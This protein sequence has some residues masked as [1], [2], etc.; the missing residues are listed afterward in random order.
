M[1]RK[2]NAEVEEQLEEVTIRKRL[3]FEDTD[4]DTDNEVTFCN[5]AHK[6]RK[7]LKDMEEM[8]VW[9]RE[10]IKAGLVGLATSDQVTKIADEVKGHARQ[11]QENKEESRKNA[12]NIAVIQK[13]IENIE[14]GI[15]AAP[16]ANLSL[17]HI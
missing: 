2:A 15:V 4:S 9:M 12:A 13:S 1:K 3:N 8:K 10:E 16:H 14:R 17:I 6:K 11:I 7:L 5:Q